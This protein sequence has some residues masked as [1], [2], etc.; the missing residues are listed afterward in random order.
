[1]DSENQH[2]PSMGWDIM[3]CTILRIIYKLKRKSLVIS[4]WVSGNIQMSY[5]SHVAFLDLLKG[6]P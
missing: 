6:D 1:M 5:V 2:W 4:D 3:K